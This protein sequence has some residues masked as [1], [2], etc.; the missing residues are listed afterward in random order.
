MWSGFLILAIELPHYDFSRFDWLSDFGKADIYFFSGKSLSQQLYI[1]AILYVLY[2]K[3][4]PC[5]N[6]FKLFYRQS[7]NCDLI[8]GSVHAFIPCAEWHHWMLLNTE[9]MYILRAEDL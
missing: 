8:R 7:C 4:F 9:G 2:L 6:L 1:L 3:I 5:V